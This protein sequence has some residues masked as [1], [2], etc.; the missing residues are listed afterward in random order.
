MWKRNSLLAACLVIAISLFAPDGDAEAL[1]IPDEIK[2]HVLKVYNGSDQTPLHLMFESYLQ[3]LHGLLEE[4]DFEGLDYVVDTL[5]FGHTPEGERRASEIVST[6]VDA[7]A[8]LNEENLR[9]RYELLCSIE[10]AKRSKE[11]II[12]AFNAIDDVSEVIARKYFKLTANK[13]K[14]DETKRLVKRLKSNRSG[15]FY[16]SFDYASMLKDAPV[17]PKTQLESTCATLGTTQY[18]VQ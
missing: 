18:Y 7:Y 11:E 17:S 13:L 1:P 6:F 14:I 2:P 10:P 8:K 12:R 3:T 15:F 4:G 16:V 9:A 5:H